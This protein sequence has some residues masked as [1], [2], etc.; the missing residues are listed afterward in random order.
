M[1][2]ECLSLNFSPVDVSTLG[3]LLGLSDVILICH[4]GKDGGSAQCSGVAGHSLHFVHCSGENQRGV[5]V[6][7]ETCSL[8]SLFSSPMQFLV[9]CSGRSEVFHKRYY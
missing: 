7:R 2:V 1:C 5:R 4:S 6:N 8:L 9:K 3:D